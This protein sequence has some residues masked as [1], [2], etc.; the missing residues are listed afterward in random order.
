[1]DFQVKK[2]VA[3]AGGLTTEE[4]WKAFSHHQK[5]LEES[6]P[7]P[8]LKQI[9]A[10]QRRRLSP[11]AKLALHCALEAA[12]SVLETVPTVFASRHG[13]LHKTS[14]LIANV[15]NKEALS[16][17]QFGLSVHNAVAGQFS[18]FTNNKAPSTATSAGED[19]FFMALIDAVCK[20]KTNDYDSILLVYTDEIVPD[21]YKSYVM[22]NEV[23]VGSAL[24]IEKPKL[25]ANNMSL[26]F[27]ANEHSNNE[28]KTM[29]IFDFLS[30]FYGNESKSTI[31]SKRYTWTLTR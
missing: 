4:D 19:S 8:P 27:E 6:T 18:I 9:P 12:D 11:F 1:M 28:N 31:C 16:P 5:E 23:S 17:T 26:T 15:A 20:L 2:C 3:W 29:Q 7:L 30:Y 24:L 25:G 22:Q 13:D 21:I 14:Q 10:M